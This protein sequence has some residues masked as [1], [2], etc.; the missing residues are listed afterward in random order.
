MANLLNE[1]TG[2]SADCQWSRHLLC[3]APGECSCKCHERSGGTAR[4]IAY[5]SFTA[6]SGNE[7]DLPAIYTYFAPGWDGHATFSCET[8]RSVAIRAIA[9]DESEFTVKEISR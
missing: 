5:C 7:C 2:R 6:S 4:D 8:H 1:R 9:D 3:L